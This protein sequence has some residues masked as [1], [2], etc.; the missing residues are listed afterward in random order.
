MDFTEDSLPEFDLRR[1]VDWV[2]IRGNS[3]R[4]QS[5]VDGEARRSEVT[6]EER[7]LDK[8]QN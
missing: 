3:G 7:S 1:T 8:R 4:F 5:Q 2:I 6:R